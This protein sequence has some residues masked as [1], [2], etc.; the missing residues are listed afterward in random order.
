MAR[1]DY[2]PTH[3]RR[4]GQ[5]HRYVVQ[6]PGC[7][8]WHPVTLH[9]DSKTTPAALWTNKGGEATAANA[10][11]L[12]AGPPHLGGSCGSTTT[13]CD[14]CYAAGM[15]RYDAVAAMVRQNLESLR[16]VAV[17]G[18]HALGE[19]LTALVELSADEQRAQGVT[20]PTFRWHSDGDAGALI[21][22]GT[23]RRVYPRAIRQ[24]ARNTPNVMHWIY[25][26]ELWAIPH[27]IG[28]PNLRVLISADRDNINRAHR[29][30]TRYDVPL[31]LLGDDANDAATLW[32]RIGSPKA[33]TCPATDKWTHDG[34]G[35]AHIVGPDGRRSTLTKGQPAVGACIAC[36]ACLPGG[37][38]R[39]ITF[40]L[41]GRG[42]R[43]AGAI[44]KR[45]IPL[46]VAQ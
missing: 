29:V 11:A 12:P 7:G 20:T 43:L 39:N 34:I 24:A 36:Q 13:V 28:A 44:A 3:P 40:H 32:A 17:H 16:H 9:A 45:R 46:A 38:P 4:S 27:L 30:A 26:R 22:T 19:W 33:V 18:T 25:T 2:L 31:A 1:A 42:N 23:D 14:S 37:A 6:C 35:P 10:F 15:E 8:E 41:H 5:S 21:G